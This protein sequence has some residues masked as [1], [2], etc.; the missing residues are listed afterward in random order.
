[1][2][3]M[4]DRFMSGD[5]D[6]AAWRNLED[7]A[8]AEAAERLPTA[9]GWHQIA[10][11]IETAR[12]QFGGSDVRSHTVIFDPEQWQPYA[13]ALPGQALRTKCISR[14]DVFEIA[15]EPASAEGS[16]RLFCSSY[17]WGQGSNGYG[18]A[19]I[20]RIIRTTPPQQ[21]SAIIASARTHL[22]ACGP[23]SAYASLRGTDSACTVPHWGPAF[24][25]KLLHFA[26]TPSAADSAVILDNLTARVVADVSGLPH[27]V[28]RRGRSERWTAYRYG[29]YLA[30]M[31]LVSA[32]LD[33]SP[34]LLEYALFAEGRRQRT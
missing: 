25:T 4:Q 28:D 18:R 3:I 32:K 11:A 19:R 12:A 7:E 24:F 23:L 2:A 29:V 34:D 27:L 17:I 20:E 6:C 31:T 26:D 8:R 22:A 21:L 9:E 33:V 5:I 1:M 10:Q 30:W 15:A 16:W 14:G 13:R